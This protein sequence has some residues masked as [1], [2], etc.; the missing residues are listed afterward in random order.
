MMWAGNDL[1]FTEVFRA[2]RSKQ[3]AQL[4]YADFFA[5]EKGLAVGRAN[6]PAP[7]TGV[8]AQVI[9]KRG[10]RGR[11]AFDELRAVAGQHAHLFLDKGR[12]VEHEGLLQAQPQ[13]DAEIVKDALV[14]IRLVEHGWLCQLRPQAVSRP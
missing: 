10:R 3:I 12:N 1:K 9:Q 11:P 13:M 14:I 5:A 8:I 6:R 2:S 7:V 4:A